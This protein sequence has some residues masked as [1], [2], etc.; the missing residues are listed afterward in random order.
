MLCG[1][2]FQRDKVLR[3]QGSKCTLVTK[4]DPIFNISFTPKLKMLL[5]CYIM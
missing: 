1:P 4:F 2:Q 5:K 3:E